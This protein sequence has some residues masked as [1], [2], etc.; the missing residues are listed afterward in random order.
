MAIRF[1][2]I[3]R[4]SPRDKSVKYYASIKHSTISEKQFVENIVQKNTCTR[5]DVLAVI[6]SV[7]DELVSCIRNGQNVTLPE[8]GSFGSS[9]SS[10]GSATKEAFTAANITRLSVRFRPTSQFRYDCAVN[11]PAVS[12]V[13]DEPRTD[14]TEP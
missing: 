5:A 6:A 13:N 9:C 1:K 8:I 10:K 7:K 3:P 11:N 4:K 12:F 2:V 14:E